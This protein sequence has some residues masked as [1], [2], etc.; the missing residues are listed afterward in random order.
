[1]KVNSSQSN[2]IEIRPL[3][4]ENVSPYGW[5]LGKSIR[6]DSSIPT[7]TSV[8][9]TYRNQQR[10]VTSLEVHRLTQQA[11]VPLTGEIVHVVAGHPSRRIAGRRQHERSACLWVRGFACAPVAGIPREWTRLK[12]L[13]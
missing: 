10:A 1:M 11:I 4:V 3:T 6:L 5:L 12:L 7:F 9:I 8:E 2:L 13:A